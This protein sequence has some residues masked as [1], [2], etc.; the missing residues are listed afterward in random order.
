MRTDVRLLLLLLALF[1]PA[2]TV[3]AQGM[4]AETSGARG[5]RVL[6]LTSNLDEGLVFVDSVLVGVARQRHFR[7]ST[8]AKLVHVTVPRL[9]SWSVTPLRYELPADRS[10]E[11][12]D[13]VVTRLDFP[14]YYRLNS[15]PPG[16]AVRFSGA[17]ST[18]GVTPLVVERSEPLSGEVSFSR[19]GFEEALW[20][21]GVSVWNSYTAELRPSNGMSSPVASVAPQRKRRWI[22]ALALGV[23]G[24]AA[25]VAVHYKFKADRRYE[26]YE[27]NGDPSLRP[28]I[29]RLDIRSGVALG[30]MQVGLG[31]FAVRM[32][33]D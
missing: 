29:R 32:V 8:D 33:L 27:E 18:A 28:E 7:V 6:D 20:Q 10:P 1:V 25:A 31:V 15:N 30:V 16:A 17:S 19:A 3:L 21:P 24:G 4:G 23:A 14:Y 9:G 22:D 2:T 5:Y 26:V 12:V 13:T 11:R